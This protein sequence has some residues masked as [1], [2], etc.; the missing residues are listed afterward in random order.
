[1]RPPSMINN[2]VTHSLP[3]VYPT[4]VGRIPEPPGGPLLTRLLFT[5]E[6]PGG[7][8]AAPCVPRLAGPLTFHGSCC[9]R[10][11]I[12]HCARGLPENRH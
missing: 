10:P 3:N 4:M 9:G 7:G 6:D 12:V 8:S 5:Q 1:M 2:D 11:G